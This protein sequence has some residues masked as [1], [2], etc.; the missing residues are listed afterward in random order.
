MY[1]S[2]EI[3]WFSTQLNRH[4]CRWFQKQRLEFD[5]IDPRLDFY[6]PLAKKDIGIKLREGNIEVKH[7]VGKPQVIA[8][9]DSN[10]GYLEEWVK[11]SFEGDPSGPLYQEITAR[12]KYDWIKLYKE[13][14][15]VK[16]IKEG[17]QVKIVP[18][19]EQVLSGCQVE[20]TRTHLNGLVWFTFGL[21]WFGGA[22]WIL[23]P[24]LISEILGDIHLK[25]QQSMG[26]PEF[27]NRE[28]GASVKFW[29]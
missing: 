18:I 15:G 27:L 10:K 29:K 3:R 7:R 24:N 21:E 2:K 23:S 25:K 4:I 28:S 11:W 20:Y 8:L 22:Y 12:E 26:Y 17:T 1:K 14:L 6:L 16:L 5:T 13:R 19:E 9:K